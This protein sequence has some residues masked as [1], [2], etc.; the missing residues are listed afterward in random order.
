MKYDTA[1]MLA[2][3]GYEREVYDRIKDTDPK[4]KFQFE[5]AEELRSRV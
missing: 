1:K 4:Y 5:L 3:M 2:D